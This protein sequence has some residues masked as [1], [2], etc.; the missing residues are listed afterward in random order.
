[1]SENNDN[2]DNDFCGLEGDREA[3]VKIGTFN[4]WLAMALRHHVNPAKDLMQR[5]NDL[6]TNHIHEYHMSQATV[7]GALTALIWL[8]PLVGIVVPS[9]LLFILYLMHKSAL[10]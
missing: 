1:M 2:Q 9:L 7:K 8:V 3:P 10:I 5:N 6:L 4:R